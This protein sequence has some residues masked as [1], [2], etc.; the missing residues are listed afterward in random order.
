MK[1]KTCA[2]YA[3]HLFKMT[4]VVIRDIVVSLKILSNWQIGTFLGMSHFIKIPVFGGFFNRS[5]LLAVCF[6]VKCI[7]KKR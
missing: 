7:G 3:A 6:W 5:D 4:A 2:E 1:T